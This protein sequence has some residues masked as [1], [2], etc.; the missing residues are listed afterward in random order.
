MLY[1]Y[2]EKIRKQYL[3]EIIEK[4]EELYD[5]YYGQGEFEAANLV[6]DMVAYLQEDYESMSSNDKS[7]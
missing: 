7:L 4:F 3:A 5:D 1:L 2:K 6:I